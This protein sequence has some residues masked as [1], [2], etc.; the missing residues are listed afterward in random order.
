MKSVRML[1]LMGLVA[2]CGNALPSLALASEESSVAEYEVLSA[3]EQRYNR[4]DPNT[5][6]YPHWGMKG[7]QCL[8]SCGS[9]GGTRGLS[10]SCERYGM[11]DMG[12]AYDV[13]YCCSGDYR[14][15]GRDRDRDRDR[16]RGRQC[17]D[18]YGRRVPCDDDRG[19]ECTD[20]WG[21]RVPCDD[22]RGRECTD[23]YG[24]RIPCR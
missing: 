4:C 17:T 15:G 12:N 1:L 11:R 6:P 19:R 3:E 10:E 9:L 24:R 2:L 20:R 16:D 14:D 18:R 7:G 21:R 13:P 22:D 8:K 23:R 5:Q